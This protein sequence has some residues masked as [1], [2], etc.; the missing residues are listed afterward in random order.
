MSYR[1]SNVNRVKVTC[2]GR[3]RASWI[4]QPNL[5]DT[6]SLFRCL[7]F[8]LFPFFPLPSSFFSFS[9][10]FF[11]S[12]FLFFFFLLPF[13]RGVERSRMARLYLLTRYVS[14]YTRSSPGFME[15]GS[16]AQNEMVRGPTAAW[17]P[18]EIAYTYCDAIFVC[19]T[20]MDEGTSHQEANEYYSG[21]HL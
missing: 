6:R 5:Y 20:A 21:I 3:V 8:L 9:S 18:R 7:P 16:W 12:F 10:F 11:L 17:K 4:V 13:R 1:L 19:C 14:A 15:L 2:R